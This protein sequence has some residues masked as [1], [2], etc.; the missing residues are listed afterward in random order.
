M[1]R[2]FATG[3]FSRAGTAAATRW[4][5]RLQRLA[6]TLESISFSS[7]PELRLVLE[8]DARHLPSFGARLNLNAAAADTP[9]G[10]AESVEFV[11]RLFPADTNELARVEIDLHAVS[12]QTRW[13]NTT[14]LN[15][16]LR[17]VSLAPRPDVVDASLTLRASVA[18]T[19]WAAVTPIQLK[20]H[21]VHAVTNP[22]PQSGTVELA[23]DMAITPWARAAGLQVT[24]A[25]APATNVVAPDPAL[26]WWTNF[27]R[28]QLDWT[29]EVRALKAYRLE[30]EGVQGAGQWCPPNLSITNLHARLYRGTLDAEARLDVLTRALAFNAGCNFDLKE[31]AT[32]LTG[33]ARDGFAK[34]TWNEPPELRWSGSFNLPAWTEVEPDWQAAVLPTLQAAGSVAATNVAFGGIYANWLRTHFTC[35]NRLWQFPELTLGRP[36]GQL[37]LTHTL[38]EATRDFYFGIRSTLDLARRAFLAARRGPGSPGPVRV[39]QPAASG[40]RTAGQLVGPQSPRLPGAAGA[41][42]FH[43]PPV[44]HRRHRHP[45]GVHQSRAVAG[46]GAGVA[47]GASRHGGGAGG[48]F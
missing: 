42:E 8:G 47:R 2:P 37:A 3:I 43:L 10:Q 15:L 22:I 46:R 17:L 4:P 14:N 41:D 24:A 40:G 21:W 18:E 19:P 32:F 45:T 28:Y 29:A 23:T 39:C 9:W 1:R 20:A 16:Q 38:N 13:A 5:E 44:Q 7:P 34:V 31:L 12:A 35:T 25:L 33:G 6:D 30:V 27:L 48:G 26:A 11:S 36:E